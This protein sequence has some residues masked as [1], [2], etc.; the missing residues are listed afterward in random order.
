MIFDSHMHIGSYDEMFD[1]RLD[2]DGIER[3]MQEHGIA[4][5]VVF[6]PD[7]ASVARA[8]ESVAGL[9]GLVWS[10]PRLPGYLDEAR[11]YLDN[12]RFLGMKLHPLIDGYHPNSSAVHPLIELLLERDLPVLIHSGHPIF[13][14][15]WSIEELIVS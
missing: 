15:P 11:E 4:G 6:C 5:G 8:V 3:L 1:V 12:P 9:Y 10:N 7:N 2:R 14:L 13:T